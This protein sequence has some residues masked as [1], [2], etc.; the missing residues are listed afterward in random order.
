MHIL[1]HRQKCGDSP[2]KP[3]K[4]INIMTILKGEKKQKYAYALII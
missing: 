1:H 2:V 4:T 3:I